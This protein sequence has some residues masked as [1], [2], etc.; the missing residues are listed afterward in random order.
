[1][2]QRRDQRMDIDTEERRRARQDLVPL[3][4]PQA[5]VDA[6]RGG[7]PRPTHPIPGVVD[8][9]AATAGEPPAGPGG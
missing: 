1:M 3:A 6:L 9:D 8:R 4:R 2:V 7:F 5:G